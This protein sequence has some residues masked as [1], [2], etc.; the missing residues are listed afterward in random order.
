M[1]V[2]DHRVV[3]VREDRRL[4]VG[5]DREQRLRALATGDVLRRAADPAGDVEVGRDLRPGLADLVGVRPPAGA[6]D[7]ARAADRGVEQRRELLEDRE[8]LR[9]PDPAPTGDDDL[10]VGERDLSARVRSDVVDD[11]NRSVER[12]VTKPATCV[13]TRR[14]QRRRTALR[15]AGCGRRGA[16]PPR[17]A[18]RPSG[19]AS[20]RRLAPRVTFAA[21]GRSSCAA[22][23]ASTSLPRSEP[24][25]TMSSPPAAS[26]IAAA[27]PPARTGRRP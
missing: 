19:C 8:A 16:A 1:Q 18:C 3:G 9:G 10:G 11:C 6:R 13:S 27:Q 4:A 2:A 14:W 26:T 23:C 12:A 7:D 22:T 17:A 21:N 5:V 24:G 25:P 20:A 15:S